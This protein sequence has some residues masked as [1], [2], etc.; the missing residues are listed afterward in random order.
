MKCYLCKNE[1][2]I[3]VVEKYQYKES[4]LNNVYLKN[5]EVRSCENCDLTSPLIP[6][7]IRLHNTIARAIVCKKTL[8][9]GEE[10]RF[11]R[12]NLRL[13][14]QDWASCLRKDAATVSRAEKDGNV[15]NKDL[16]LLIRLAYIRAF[17]EK[18]GEL[19]S[20]K[21][22]ESL[23]IIEDIELS[24]LIDVDKIDEFSYFEKEEVWEDV[25][26]DELKFEEINQDAIVL[27]F[28]RPN[29]ENKLYA[30]YSNLALAA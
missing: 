21:I 13:K 9:L 5:I 16:D 12:K 17:E 25:I 18:N 29:L 27:P 15:L 6:K 28:A 7:I 4:G 20:E 14:A 24:I 30:E 2:Q 23:S 8:L 22:I 3:K 19:F 10:I 1:T 26:N 11:L